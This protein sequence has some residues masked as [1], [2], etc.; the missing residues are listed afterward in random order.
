MGIALHGLKI[1]TKCAINE[2]LCA[3]IERITGFPLHTP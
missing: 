2:H 1:N 3:I